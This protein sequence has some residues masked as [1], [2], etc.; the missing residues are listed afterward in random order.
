MTM[1]HGLIS[2]LH[3]QH[4]M[5]GTVFIIRI[6]ISKT[7]RQIMPVFYSLAAFFA[8]KKIFSL[9]AEMK[10]YLSE[11]FPK[12]HKTTYA[13]KLSSALLIPRAKKQHGAFCQK[14]P[15]IGN[16]ISCAMQHKNG[17]S[18]FPACSPHR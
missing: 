16:L 3:T 6:I 1:Q 14:I 8:M 13:K 2:L 5:A 17:A 4:L 9:C 15:H 7:T 18:L 11:N 12:A 10:I